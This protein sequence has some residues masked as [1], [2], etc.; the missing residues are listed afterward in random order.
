MKYYTIKKNSAVRLI[1]VVDD[2]TIECGEETLKSDKVFNE[3]WFEG[4]N[5]CECCDTMVA[6]F[7][8]GKEVSSKG[9]EFDHYATTDA[10]NVTE[11]FSEE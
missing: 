1:C 5:K 10:D 8:M 3:T 6:N 11:V 9:T 2:V 7:Y 4:Y